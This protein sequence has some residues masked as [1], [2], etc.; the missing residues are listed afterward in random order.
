MRLV[1][2]NL[3]TESIDYLEINKDSN[4]FLLGGRGLTS[5]IVNN[6]VPPDSDPL[7]KMNKLIIASGLLTGSPFPNSA[8]T[9][10]GGK[11]PLTN[12]I[13][14]ANV[15]GRGSMMLARNGFRAII[16][17]EKLSEWKLILI[18]EQNIELKDGVEYISMGN[19][20]LCDNLYK[21]YGERIGI[22]SI[23]PSGENL[24][25]SSTIAA[26]DLQGYP[27]RH[28]ARGGL[29]AVMGSKKIKAIVIFPP[30]KSLVKIKDIKRLRS[31]S[32]PFTKIL[33]TTKR[34]FSTFGTPLL[35]K[36]INSLNGLPTKNFSKGKFSKV[37]SISGE[38]LNKLIN[39][40]GGRN[41]LA[42]CP[43]CVIK[44][45]NQICD[46]KGKYITSSLEYE[47]IAMN[48][49]NLLID[50][51]DEI[52]RIDFL[53]DNIGIDTIEFGCTIG[54]A[55]E[56]GKI[57]WGNS[58]KVI[59]ILKEIKKGSDLGNLYGNGVCYLAD[60]L[61]IQRIPHVKGQAISAYDPRIFKGMSVT[62]ATSPMGAD[63][64][65]GAAIAGRSARKDKD[66]GDLTENEGKLELSYELQLYTA[67]LDSMGCCYFIGPSYENMEI[68]KGALNAMY[69]V[70]WTCKDIIDLG[71]NIIKTE[72]EF[73]KKAG[74]IKESNELP[75]FFYSEKSDPTKLKA[76]FSK[77]ELINFWDRLEF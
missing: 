55:M 23:G 47:T 62:F 60:Q 43:T 34:I 72:L 36:A 8:R 42:C 71:K 37:D 4:Y 51:L 41:R 61:K 45:S 3:K 30:K 48:G 2:I 25:K 33:A 70:N 19:Y 65:A 11:S 39:E 68:I 20:R 53:C 67:I 17:E 14:E 77:K 12:G 64:T 74:L 38:T 52:S 6:E 44:C 69:G 40:R 31:I 21:K 75:S 56:A 9:S 29:G 7:G 76:T 16:L 1:R 10:I 50:D 18:K 54:L 63:H 57:K 22:Y 32:K 46:N 49:S 58:T 5:H 24:M 35:I 73:N 59:E 13:K 26:N 27:S 15:G 66:Y 28:A